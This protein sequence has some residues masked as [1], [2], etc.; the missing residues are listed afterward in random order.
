MAR[1]PVLDGPVTSTLDVTGPFDVSAHLAF[2]RRRAVPG[3]EVVGVDTY[4]HTLRLL[5]GPAL[6]RLHIRPDRVELTLWPTHLDDVAD[7]VRRA[8]WLLDL[9]TDSTTVDARLAK[10][11][12]LADSVRRHPGLRVPG[13]VDGFEVA[14]RAVV[15]QQISGSGARTILGQ[16]VTEFGE[17][18]EAGEQQDMT[19]LFPTPERLMVADPERL[20]MPRSRGRALVGV[21]AAVASGSLVIERGG[22]PAATRAALLAVRG[23]G[24]WTA[25]YVALRALGDPDVFMASDLGVRRGLAR[26]G[27]ADAGQEL[28]DRWRPWRSYALMHVWQA[29][30]MTPA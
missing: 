13:Q 10:D 2:L 9:S 25:D 1:D 16:L 29:L 18:L 4:A 6:M 28:A 30:E 3:V 20:P 26:L 8:Q 23:I 14:V 7:G 24:P 17:R 5:H 27:L 11:P 21:A 12:S 15:G 19:H 22:D